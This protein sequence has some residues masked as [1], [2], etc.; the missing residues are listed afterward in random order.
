VPA[1]YV[2]VIW[3]R[4]CDGLFESEEGASVD[5]VAMCHFRV[6][7]IAAQNTLHYFDGGR[8]DWLVLVDAMKATQSPPLW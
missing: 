7:D 8:H 3:R 5:G 2:L 6:E 1:K 4:P